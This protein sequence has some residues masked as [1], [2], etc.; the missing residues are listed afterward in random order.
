MLINVVSSGQLPERF[1]TG[2]DGN[3]VVTGVNVDIAD[4][5]ENDNLVG[6]ITKRGVNKGLNYGAGTYNPKANQANNKALNIPNCINFTIN[7]GASLSSTAWGAA[8]DDKLGIIWVACLVKFLN[9]GIINLLGKG[10]GGGAGGGDSGAGTDGVDGKGIG[11]GH[12][13]IGNRDDG[14]CPMPVPGSGG[15]GGAVGITYGSSAIPLITWANLYGSGGGGG[16]GKNDA[17]S[18]AECGGGGAG[19]AH[20][21]LGAA[22]QS[23]TGLDCT[24]DDVGNPG[25]P[26]GGAL[27]VYALMFDTSNGT[28]ICNGTAGTGG[29]SNGGGGGGGSGGTVFAE[30]FAGAILGINKITAAGG[31]KGDVVNNEGGDGGAGG[32]GRI[33]IVGP[34]SGSTSNPPI[35]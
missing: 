3:I 29:G 21:A 23:Y 11:H 20:A 34:Y 13:G 24:G 8:T 16:G 19:A 30:T 6:V 7:V 9:L 4:V 28:I 12:K 27:R 14:G 33:H 15:Q 5:Y 10:A 25:G 17:W 31:A 2:K 26:G 35:A 1:G 18:G 22:G 32:A